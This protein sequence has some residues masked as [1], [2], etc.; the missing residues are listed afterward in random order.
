[1]ALSRLENLYRAVIL[2][3]SSSPRNFGELADANGRLELHNPT[4]GDV[5]LLHVRITD[6]VI[7]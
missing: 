3:H 2:D 4:C 1:M 6:D 7:E 5:I